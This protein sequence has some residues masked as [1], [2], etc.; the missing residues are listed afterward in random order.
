[1]NT[2]QSEELAQV[3]NSLFSQGLKEEEIIRQLREKGTADTILQE[4]IEKVKKRRSH[5]K[6]NSGFLWCGIGIFLLVT[7]F[8]LTIMLYH[9]GNQIRFV[10]YGLTSIGLVCTV[11]G[12]I[13][14]LGW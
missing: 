14:L 7:G 9:S 12:M 3:A 10:M 6:R 13:S 1:M 2:I 11:K 5:K 4:V 8:L